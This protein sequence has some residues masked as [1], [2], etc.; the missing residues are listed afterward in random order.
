MQPA[1]PTPAGVDY[2]VAATAD[3]CK[4]DGAKVRR[5]V[6]DGASNWYK[7]AVGDRVGKSTG[8]TFVFNNIR[9]LEIAPANGEA[10]PHYIA[11][12]FVD[13]EPVPG[14]QWYEFWE[15]HPCKL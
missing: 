8:K 14:T 11:A 5:V 12:Q 1:D 13:R 9:F 6:T 4:F 7:L 15:T 3:T 2:Y 10:G